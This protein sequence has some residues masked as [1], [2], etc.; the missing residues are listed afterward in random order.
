M[1]KIAVTPRFIKDAKF[2]PTKI[3]DQTDDIIAM[4]CENP[5]NSNLNIKKLSGINP[6]VRRIR[7]GSYHLIYIF[8][9]K[10]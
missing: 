6:L 9:K 4:F 3:K 10:I 7:I 8:H 5:V 1:R 2:V